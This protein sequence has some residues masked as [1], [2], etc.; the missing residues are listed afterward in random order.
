MLV[1]VFNSNQLR[2]IQ[3]N[4]MQFISIH[5]NSNSIQFDSIRF[6]SIRFDFIRQS[7]PIELKSNQFDSIQ[8]DASQSNSIISVSSFGPGGFFSLCFASCTICHHP[9]EQVQ[10]LWSEN[11]VIVTSHVFDACVFLRSLSFVLTIFCSHDST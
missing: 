2:S 5:F 7:D 6:D 1:L 9:L 8:F 10:Y 11:Y 4:S 3:F